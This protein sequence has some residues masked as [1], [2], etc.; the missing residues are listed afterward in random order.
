MSAAKKLDVTDFFQGISVSSDLALEMDVVLFL[1]PDRRR[2][3]VSRG[4]S[5][6]HN[7]VC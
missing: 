7:S 1:H 5:K 4:I 2:V 6:W 3:L